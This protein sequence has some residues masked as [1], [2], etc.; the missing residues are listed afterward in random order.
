MRDR[1]NTNIPESVASAV[2]LDQFDGFY[3]S[4]GSYTAS[5]SLWHVL[6]DPD[7]RAREEELERLRSRLMIDAL[8]KEH[9][10][11]GMTVDR[12]EALQEVEDFLYWLGVSCDERV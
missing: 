9:G 2:L 1:L 8:G 6:H 12:V 5:A 4:Y 11:Q 3:R 10:E 7:P